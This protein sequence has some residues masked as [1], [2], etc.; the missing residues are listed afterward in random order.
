MTILAEAFHSFAQPLALTAGENDSL[1]RLVLR[2]APEDPGFWVQYA[3]FCRAQDH[4]S[5][6]KAALAEADRLLVEVAAPSNAHP[7]VP[8]LVDILRWR[9]ARVSV[10][11]GKVLARGCPSVRE[12][13]LVACQQLVALPY[14]NLV[15][16]L[17]SSLEGS[18]PPGHLENHLQATLGGSWARQLAQLRTALNRSDAAY[19]E[20]LSDL[21]GLADLCTTL[22][23]LGRYDE[24]AQVFDRVD[25]LLH[26]AAK[27]ESQRILTWYPALLGWLR[28]RLRAP[29]A[30]LEP[31]HAQG[32]RFVIGMVVWGEAFLNALERYPLPCL[33]APGNLPSLSQVHEVRLVIFTTPEGVERLESSSAVQALRPYAIVDLVP[34]PTLLTKTHET[35]KLMSAAHVAAMELARDSGAHFGFLAPDIVLADNFLETLESRRQ[36]GAEVVFVPSVTLQMETFTEAMEAQFPV[37]EG[38]RRLP[39]QKLLDLGLQNVHPFVQQAY[40]HATRKRRPSGSILLWPLAEAPGYLM[41]GFH[42]TP[43]LVSAEAMARF[44]GSF[45][46]TIDGEFLLKILHTPNQLSRCEL[47]TDPRETCFFE[48]SKGSRFDFPLEFDQARLARW[49]SLQGPVAHWLFPQQVHLANVEPDT[50]HRAVD[51]ASAVVS[52]LQAQA[53]SR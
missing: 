17:R 26:Q 52:N 53:D 37:T 4:A 23:G 21:P 3:D 8:V 9:H 29:M 28:P 11:L 38:V 27:D 20:A 44:D 2:E 18:G 13:L 10:E 25:P 1:A 33:L 12:E 50:C 24:A 16:R 46:F 34:F 51:Q 22:M 45:F 35:Y 39:P 7:V 43:Y 30:H 36:A 49:A 14:A 42:H 41:H 19:A 48:L 31:W 32:S 15:A 5:E 47:L 40:T 6:A